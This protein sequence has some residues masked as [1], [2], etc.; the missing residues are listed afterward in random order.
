MKREVKKVERYEP[1]K[2]FGEVATHVM[3]EFCHSASTNSVVLKGEDVK[4]GEDITILVCDEHIEKAK[5]HDPDDPFRLMTFMRNKMVREFIG[6]YINKDMCDKIK[7]EGFYFLDQAISIAIEDTKIEW[8]KI[9]NKGKLNNLPITCAHCGR[10]TDNKTLQKDKIKQ[11][12][13]K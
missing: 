11:Y 5:E 2:D 4:Y 1:M 6:R 10:E 9:A 13:K 7:Y 12:E 3:C 8:M